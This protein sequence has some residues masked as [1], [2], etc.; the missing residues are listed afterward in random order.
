MGIGEQCLR[1]KDATCDSKVRFHRERYRVNIN[2]GCY[3]RKVSMQRSSNLF[4]SRYTSIRREVLLEILMGTHCLFEASSIENQRAD[5]FSRSIR[6]STF[7]RQSHMKVALVS[8]GKC[9]NQ[10]QCHRELFSS[11]E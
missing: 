10:T 5:I 1:Q 4:E 6:N 7:A 11:S 8:S 9:G 3:P 2:T